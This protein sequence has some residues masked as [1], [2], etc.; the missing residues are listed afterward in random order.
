MRVLL[1]QPPHYYGNN[2]RPPQQFPLGLGYI[3]RVL[4]D[5]GHDLVVLD[6]YAHQYSNEEVVKKLNAI[7]PEPDVVCISALSTQYRYVK[8][9]TGVLKDRFDKPLVIGNA[10]STFSADV[11]FKNTRADI[12]VFG[13]GEKTIIEL[14]RNL[15]SPE[16]VSGIAYREGQ[17]VRYTSRR[18]YIKELDRIEFPLREVFPF[19]IYLNNCYLWGHP[20]IR[21]VSVITARGCPYKC[22]FCSK[23]FAGARLRSVKNVIDEIESLRAKYDFNGISFQDELTLV[24]KERVYQLCEY[25]KNS[26][27]SWICQGR[28]NLVDSELL[29]CMKD[30][31]CVALGFGVESGSQEILNKMNKA[32]TV[33]MAIKAIRATK[34]A[35]IK[36]IIQMM[37][38][39]P[40]ESDDTLL[41]TAIFF[42][43]IK[44][45]AM[46]FSMTTALPGT[47]LYEMALEKGLIKDENE[48]MEKL[49]WG[50]YGDRDVLINFTQFPQNELTGKMREN[51]LRINRYYR[52]YLLFHPWVIFRELFDRVKSYYARHGLK[53]TI[54]RVV[55]IR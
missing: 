41:Q 9:L 34:K 24:N 27:L 53:K 43:K 47:R 22:N 55:R 16:K 11:V 42:K 31:G 35:G 10:L 36:P 8:W 32:I 54:E 5:A 2:S 45:P 26:K 14:L 15:N 23:T 21:A 18:E 19:E 6:I 49:D 33:D 13:E 25:L 30:S 44:S 12:C 48:Y 17:T 40:G 29:K 46:P 4:N 3:A 7:A 50:Y 1:V 51:E 52:Q 20:E 28:V 37:Y 38:G 39:Y